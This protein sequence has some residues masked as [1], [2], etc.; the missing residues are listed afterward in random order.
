M[1]RVRAFAIFPSSRRRSWAPITKLR[2][3]VSPAL[4]GSIRSHSACSL[5]QGDM[6]MTRLMWLEGT[7]N[8]SI[9]HATMTHQEGG[10]GAG[11]R[12]RAVHVHH[13]R[14]RPAEPRTG[15]ALAKALASVAMRALCVHCMRTALKAPPYHIEGGGSKE[16]RVV[17]A[18]AS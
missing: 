8:P 4:D 6:E 9:A 5:G 17:V 1:G 15:H 14:R 7:R 18:L 3:G 16:G 11:H 13:G 12:T 2:C 10:P